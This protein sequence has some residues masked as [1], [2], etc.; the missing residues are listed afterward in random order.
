[1]AAYNR[2]DANAVADH[3]SETGQWTSPSGEQV[4]G[5]AA[6]AEQMQSIF[7]AGDAPQIEVSEPRIRLISAD[8][9]IEEGTARV[10]YPGEVPGTSDYIAIHVKK[11]GQWK[12]D[13]IRESE[14][15]EGPSA[16]ENLKQLEWMVGEWVDES[17]NAVVEHTCR[18]SEDGH[19]L[20]G[21]FTVQVG[22]RPAMSGSVRIGWDA[23]RQQIRSWVFDSEG[24][25][26]EGFWTRAD[27]RWIVKM[28]GVRPDGAAAS[29][30]NSYTP[31]RA[32]AF[33]FTTADRV[34]GNELQPD[35]SIT[36]VRKPPQPASQ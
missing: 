6:I 34:V 13:S 22:D 7:A 3:W 5:R 18:W 9:A 1:V 12:L 8:V 31:L 28:T 17:P 30:T 32:D 16:A 29:T 15:P 24:G 11:N 33:L 26:A 25:F 20:L 36:V 10:T 4:Q 19:F 27:D 35:Q 2:G 14:A 23:L 21:E